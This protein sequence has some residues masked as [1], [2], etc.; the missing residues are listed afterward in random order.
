MVV[1]WLSKASQHLV[2]LLRELR[3]ARQLLF[4]QRL[5]SLFDFLFCALVFLL[6]QSE[7][8]LVLVFGVLKDFG[9]LGLL[10]LS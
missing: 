3:H 6:E 4:M 1:R 10:Y 5:V 8:F 9:A 2:L 7:F